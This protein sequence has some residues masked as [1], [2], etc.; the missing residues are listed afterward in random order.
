MV[1]LMKKLFFLIFILLFFI[2]INIVYASD[3][4]KATIVMDMDSGR[5]LYEKNKDEKMLIASITK[6]MTAVIAIEN[7]DLNEIVVIG[8]EV[9]PT[10]GS[11]TYIEVG[12]E[13]SLRDLL[14]GLMLRSG[15][16]A[17]VSI[18]KY[19]AGSEEKFVELM[20]RKARLLGMNNTL[21]SNSTGLDD[22]TKNY[23]SAYDMAKLMRYA[24]T[25]M[26]FV[27]IAGTKKW[28]VST[29]KKSYVWY[30]RDKL[31]TEYKYST[32]GKTGYTPKAG[33]TLVSTA[34]KN[35]LN[36][37]AVTLN[38]ANHYNTQKELFEYLFSIYKKQIIINKSNISFDNSLYDNMYVNYNFYFPLK[39]DEKNMIKKYVNFYNLNN[40]N[41]N[42]EVGEIYIVFKDE[43][44]YRE[45]IYA[46]KNKKNKKSFFQ[47]I[48]DFFDSLF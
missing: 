12:E 5:I 2:D 20:N 37:V 11:N 36:L 14:Y 29:N 46:K 13:I 31:L 8:E 9:L 40:Y 45:K 16:D 32:G 35:G 42:Q 15:N 30:N 3:T 25:L 48:V 10:Y 24:N 22:D 38:D 7:K 28:T 4:S 19:V 41:D 27:E 6:I 17:A 18:A 39:T 33:K 23:S 47:K 34:S 44:V 26:E 1:I 43:E 21:F